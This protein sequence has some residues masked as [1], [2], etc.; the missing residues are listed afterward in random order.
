MPKESDDFIAMYVCVRGDRS[1]GP[2][3]AIWDPV[4]RGGVMSRRLLV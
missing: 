3:L 4:C 2:D 1:P